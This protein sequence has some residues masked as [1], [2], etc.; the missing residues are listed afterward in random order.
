M[1]NFFESLFQAKRG[2]SFGQ[3]MDGRIPYPILATVS[4][5]LP[6]RKITVADPANPSIESAPLNR[7]L[8]DP[9]NDPPMPLVGSTV[10]VF[11]VD[12]LPT[13]GWYICCQNAVNPPLSKEDQVEDHTKFVSKV[14]Y[15]RSEESI[16]LNVGSVMFSI[17]SDS[18]EITGAT[19]VKI[20]GKQVATIGA[21]DDDGDTLIS[22]GWD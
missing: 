10:M 6:D 8:H 18:V 3:D 5:H 4:R 15:L 19:N 13:N 16:L 11:Y 9:N 7:L 22:K 1:S 2:A 20:N 21:V 12:G 17:S 14:F